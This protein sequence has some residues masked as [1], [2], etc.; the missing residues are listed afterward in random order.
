MYSLLQMFGDCFFGIK[1]WQGIV[2]RAWSLEMIQALLWIANLPYISCT[3]FVQDH[4]LSFQFLM[5]KMQLR[6]FILLNF[7]VVYS[8]QNAEHTVS[9]WYFHTSVLTASLS[10]KKLVPVHPPLVDGF[11]PSSLFCALVK[12]NYACMHVC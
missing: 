2:E 1:G 11:I 9:A 3:I 12:L 7:S 6:L 10:Y 4:S 5:H 8:C